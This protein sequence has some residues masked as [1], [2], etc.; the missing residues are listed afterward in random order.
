MSVV[1]LMSHNQGTTWIANVQKRVLIYRMWCIGSALA[2]KLERVHDFLQERAGLPNGAYGP[3][4][5]EK[6]IC[7]AVI[8]IWIVGWVSMLPRRSMAHALDITNP[9]LFGLAAFVRILVLFFSRTTKQ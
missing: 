1:E 4:R 9:S 2:K 8:C 5:I 6:R 3:P 7:W